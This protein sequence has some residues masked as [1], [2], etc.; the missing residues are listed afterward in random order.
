MKH[1]F[2]R[3]AVGIIMAATPVAAFAQMLSG[4]TGVPDTSYSNHS[5]FQ[6]SLKS[7]PFIKLVQE[8][9]DAAVAEKHN[10]TY[11]T[12]GARK[13]NLDVFY[14]KEKA[15]A[16]R[17]A[18]IMIHGGGWRSGNRSQHHP[19]MQKLAALGYVCFTPEYRLS[20]EALFPAGVYD[21]KT[22][23]R[24]VRANA[25]LY[26]V[27]TARIVAMGFS[28]GGE[29]AAF[30]GT[31]GNMPL[32]EGPG[33]NS[34]ISSRVNAV[35]DLDGTLS[36]VHPESGEGDESKR[37]SAGTLWMGYTRKQQPGL[38]EAASPLS[39]AGANT[40]PTLFINSSVARMHAGR[41]DYIRI[42][43]ENGIYTQVHTF[44]DAPHSFPLF[45]PWFQPMV[46]H[47]NDFLQKAFT[48]KAVQGRTNI[49]VAQDGTGDY[50]TIQD[51]INAVRAYS[52]V[53]I[54]IHIKN[55]TYHEK[56]I[57]PSWLSDVSFIGESREKTIITNADYSGKFMNADT[58]K[59]EKFST[60]NSYTVRVQGNDITMENLT[61][62]NT[63]GRVGQ[64]VALHVDGDRFVIRN[65]S[66]LGNQDTLLTAGDSNRQ[67]YAN[68]LIAGTTDFI[69][70][71]ATAVFQDCTIKS[72]NNSYITAAS[73]TPLQQF[74]YVF[75][76]C[77][78][79]ANDE[80]KKVYLGRPWRAY[81][82][83]A[84]I[85]CE[86]EEHILPE[87]W[88]NWDNVANESTAC[89]AEYNNKGAGA[90]TGKRVAWSRQLSAKDAEA[91]TL[92]AIFRGWLP[93]K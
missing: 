12:I 20:T 1:R 37:P 31:T 90:A 10:V 46:R 57:V 22:A 59:K 45:D 66:L 48:A 50:R 69:F 92:S 4:L 54:N 61:I 25:A 78:L 70:G 63:A 35:V 41:E 27:D 76:R 67:Y 23:I 64:A 24:W 65:C 51:A 88:H 56:I 84:F 72:L 73:T 17:T 74:G 29:L 6:S 52:P 33:C 49:T 39:Y 9:P 85:E 2:M 36:F 82:K 62:E 43:S 87:G 44:D 16:K 93:V 18:V 11:C 13:L 83:V 21:V 71:N 26:Q 75:F 77:K 47:I 68:C 7:H 86:M 30:M 28:A 79:I 81:A 80:A 32:F 15:A 3:R 89:Y 40:P 14:P 55:G 8:A 53:H 58:S 42:L 5:A 19:L 91:Y 38:W 34:G 60:F